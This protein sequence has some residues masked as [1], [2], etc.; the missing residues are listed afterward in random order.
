MT[1]SVVEA[2]SKF[3][4]RES[5]SALKR[6]VIIM[7]TYPNVGSTRSTLEPASTR[8]S[9]VANAPSTVCVPSRAYNMLHRI[10]LRFLPLTSPLEAR[11][12]SDLRDRI[13]RIRS[14]NTCAHTPHG[15]TTQHTSLARRP[16]H[17]RHIHVL[18]GYSTIPTPEITNKAKRVISFFLYG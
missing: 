13:S 2:L 1:I 9:V 18:Y 3:P 15:L 12:S 8:K 14:K 7:K 5:F 11:L 6:I 16:R 17:T 4:V 10:L